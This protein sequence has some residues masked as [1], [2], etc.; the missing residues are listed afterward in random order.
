MIHQ[1]Q[2]LLRLPNAFIKLTVFFYGLLDVNLQLFDY[3]KK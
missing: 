3:T 2:I 1:A